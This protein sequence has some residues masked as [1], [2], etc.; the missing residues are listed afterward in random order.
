MKKMKDEEL[1]VDTREMK[2]LTWSYSPYARKIGFNFVKFWCPRSVPKCVIS[3]RRTLQNKSGE[4]YGRK[5]GESRESKK[6]R[7][8]WSKVE[9]FMSWIPRLDSR[10]WY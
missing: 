4:I 3:E 10:R 8:F 5:S 6:C 1:Y 9:K 7:N 2:I